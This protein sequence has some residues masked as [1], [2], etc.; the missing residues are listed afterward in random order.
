MLNHQD[1]EIITHVNRG[2]PGGELMRRYW[3]PA[4]LSA[5]LP[6]PDC[7]PLRVRLLGEDLVA[8]RDSSGVVG[9]VGAHCPHRGA[10][11]FFGRNEENGLRCIY[12]GWKFDRTGKCVDMPNA[13]NIPLKDRLK[14]KAYPCIERAHVVWTYMG[15]MNPPPPLPQM[16]FMDLPADQVTVNKHY[17]EE[18]WLQA[19][20]GN[21]D[22]SHGPFLHSTIDSKLYAATDAKVLAISDLYFQTE[23]WNY[24]TLD[25]GHAAIVA[26]WRAMDEER[27]YWRINTFLLPCFV[28]APTISGENPAANSFMYV[29][30][31]D[32][33][34]FHYAFTWHATRPLGDLEFRHVEFGFKTEY[35]PG[36]PSRPGSEWLPKLNRR[37]N[38][39]LDRQVQR[40][41]IYSGIPQGVGQDQAASESMGPLY[42]RT[43]EHL[44][45]ADKGII[46]TRALFLRAAKALRDQGTTPPGVNNPEAYRMRAHDK[47]LPKSEANWVEAL[48]DYYT[49]RPGHNPTTP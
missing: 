11:L 16:P 42:D 4:A 27:N 44:V 30:I 20:E 21:I 40:G 25:L 38:Y 24:D 48:R 3:I 47:F 31:D 39:G 15:P 43:Q 46:A 8:F 34:C 9:L 41:L 14:H 49:Y 10:S 22:P 23:G 35:E 33:H 5:E 36:D 26:A 7:V 6:G 45:P 29:P 12:H 2:T 28:L 13:P 37:N 1:N 17:W 18:N 19:L 32:E